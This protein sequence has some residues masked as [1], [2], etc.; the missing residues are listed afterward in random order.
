[1]EKRSDQSALTPS[2]CRFHGLEPDHFSSSDLVP[3]KSF[4]L[5]LILVF[6]LPI[7]WPTPGRRHVQTPRHGCLFFNH[8]QALCW[9]WK[10]SSFTARA[11]RAA[12]RI[13]R[14]RTASAGTSARQGTVDSVFLTPA[15]PLLCILIGRLILSS[16][17]GNFSCPSR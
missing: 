4:T 15:W 2:A 3:F 6:A 16:K 1:M 12:S 9:I 11:G 14:S 5:T 13:N 10:S 17:L 7:Y 8:Y